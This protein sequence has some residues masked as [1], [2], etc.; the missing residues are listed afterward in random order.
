MRRQVRSN[1]FG[2]PLRGC[3]H[4]AATTLL[5]RGVGSGRMELDTQR[6]TPPIEAGT[7]AHCAR[8]LLGPALA[9][10]Q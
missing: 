3:D 9:T 7:W 4:S 10:P 2:M 5:G 8:H 1:G 6:M